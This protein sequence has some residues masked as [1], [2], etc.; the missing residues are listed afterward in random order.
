MS[1]GIRVGAAATLMATMGCAAGVRDDAST[2]MVGPPS[3]VQTYR[4]DAD[5]RA[6]AHACP[7][8]PWNDCDDDTDF[9]GYIEILPETMM[10]GRTTAPTRPYETCTG[11]PMSRG[12][13]YVAMTGQQLIESTS[14][15]A[16]GRPIPVPEGGPGVV[17]VAP[18]SELSVMLTERYAGDFDWNRAFCFY[19]PVGNAIV[20]PYFSSGLWQ[21][22]A[23]GFEVKAAC[24]WYDFHIHGSSGCQGNCS[25]PFVNP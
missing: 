4:R 5:P 1:T 14:V 2:A 24:S 18:G 9:Q 13:Y 16:N 6:P 12:G 8:V 11:V 7:Y 3:S 19:K 15:D 22:C 25:L 17:R 10:L 20:S 23:G 21:A